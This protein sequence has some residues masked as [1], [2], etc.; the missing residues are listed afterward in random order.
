VVADAVAA[1][2]QGRAG[3]SPSDAKPSAE[4]EATAESL[5]Q[6]DEAVMTSEGAPPA[7]AEAATVGSSA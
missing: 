5:A 3:A 2:L 1:G 4:A 6:W 7:P